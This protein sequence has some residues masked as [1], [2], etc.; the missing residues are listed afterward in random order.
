MVRCQ[1][2]EQIRQGLGGSRETR[3]RRSIREGNLGTSLMQVPVTRQ[4]EMEGWS[5]GLSPPA[6]CWD[7]SHTSCHPSPTQFQGGDE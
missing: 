3:N 1:A 4:T 7:P 6:P 5:S 2:P